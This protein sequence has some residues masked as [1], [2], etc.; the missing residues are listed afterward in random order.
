LKGIYKNI[1][2]GFFLLL[3]LGYFGSA[4]FFSHT[5]I[6]DGYIFSHSHPYSHNSNGLPVHS[7]TAN[8]YLLIDLLVHFS[9]VALA[10][11]FSADLAIT[12]G[13]NLSFGFISSLRLQTVQSAKLYRGPPEKTC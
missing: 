9:A 11:W 7:H 10:L 2:G 6:V 8:G 12:A 4:T 5:H 1:T 3:F 13:L